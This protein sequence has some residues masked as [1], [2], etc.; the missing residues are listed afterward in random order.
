MKVQPIHEFFFQLEAR[1]G[2]VLLQIWTLIR[3]LLRE[4]GSP[5]FFGVFPNFK[6]QEFLW[7][8]L[9]TLLIYLCLY[10]VVNTCSFIFAC[11]FSSRGWLLVT[12]TR[13]RIPAGFW[14]KW[15][16]TF[17]RQETITCF[18]AAGG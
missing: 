6:S 5:E 13:E 7:I 14:K 12:T 4:E 17:L 11:L 15:R 9:N 2:G 8:D 1:D 3:G 10:L 18:A 16:W